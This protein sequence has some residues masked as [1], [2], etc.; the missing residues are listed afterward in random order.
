MLLNRAYQ[1]P[2]SID[3]TGDVKQDVILLRDDALSAW[4][5]FHNGLFAIMRWLSPFAQVFIP[6][7]AAYHSVKLAGILHIMHCLSNLPPSVKTIMR[8]A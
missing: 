4:I 8:H 2:L 7:L 5:E 6:K 1:I 3:N